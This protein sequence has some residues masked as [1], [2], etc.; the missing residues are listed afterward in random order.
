MLLESPKSVICVSQLSSVGLSMFV[1]EV[2]NQLMYLDKG[3]FIALAVSS[4]WQISLCLYLACGGSPVFFSFVG[5]NLKS[6]HNRGTENPHRGMSAWV[7]YRVFKENKVHILKSGVNLCG[8]K[9]NRE[10]LRIYLLWMAKEENTMLT[11]NL[12]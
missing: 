9:K 7:V 6:H 2:F 5:K 8:I 3:S 11:T 10:E 1:L 4:R 12:E